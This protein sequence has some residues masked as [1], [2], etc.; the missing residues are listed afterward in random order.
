METASLSFL[1]IESALTPLVAVPCR[2]TVPNV[3][4]AGN[5]LRSCIFVSAYFN[6]TL[7]CWRMEM[8]SIAW[9]SKIKNKRFGWDC[10]RPA[11][12]SLLS[13]LTLYV[14]WKEIWLAATEE[15]INSYANADQIWLLC[16]RKHTI[17]SSNRGSPTA[18]KAHT[19]SG[20]QQLKDRPQPK[21]NCCIIRLQTRAG[22]KGKHLNS[23]QL[24]VEKCIRLLRI[25]TSASE[26]AS[27][28]S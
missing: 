14:E 25:Y 15:Q 20:Q 5:F 21:R 19:P 13:I 6:Q 7:E 11:H 4:I 9:A 12:V 2:L 16:I 22:V 8:W 28:D 27:I 23:R 24:C 17:S 1:S 18:K 3:T 10:R 26:C